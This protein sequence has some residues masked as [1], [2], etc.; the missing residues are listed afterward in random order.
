MTKYT[1]KKFCLVKTRHRALLANHSE[2]SGFVC[3]G[4]AGKLNHFGCSL[5]V[6]QVSHGPRAD[7][8]FLLVAASA[9][10]YGINEP[11]HMLFLMCSTVH[12]A[13]IPEA[14]LA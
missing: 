3:N 2:C 1:R 8:S 14:A 9:V 12:G 6:H 4:M 10:G 7:F 11:K 13:D 5:L